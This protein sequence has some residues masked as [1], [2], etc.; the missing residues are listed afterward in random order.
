MALVRLGGESV[1]GLRGR[2]DPTYRRC[3]KVQCSN[4]YHMVDCDLNTPLAIF[5]TPV[6][7]LV[8]DGELAAELAAMTIVRIAEGSSIAAVSIAN[9]G[10]IAPLVRLVVSG[11]PTVQQTSAAALAAIGLVPRCRNTIANAGAIPPLVQQLRSSLLGSPETAARTLAHLARDDGCDID[12]FGL[13]TFAGRGEVDEMGTPVQAGDVTDSNDDEGAEESGDG[14]VLGGAMRRE[15]VLDAGGVDALISMLDGSNIPGF[16]T[17][18]ASGSAWGKA[19]VGVAGTIEVAPIFPGSQVDF[20][21]RIGMQEQAAATIADLAL[22]DE[23]MQD[24]IIDAVGVPPLLNLIRIGTSLAQEHAARALWYLAAM[25]DNQRI[26]VRHGAISDLVIL[27]KHGSVNAQEA[28]AAGL[29]DLARGAIIAREEPL[30]DPVTQTHP[31]KHGASGRKIER[32]TRLNESLPH[33]GMGAAQPSTEAE[34]RMPGADMEREPDR[35]QTIA[36]AGGIVPLV[37]LSESG[38]SGG[39]EHAAAALWHLALDPEN[40]ASIASNGGIKPLVS[41]LENGTDIG[42]R[43]ASDALT[44]LATENQDNQAQIAKRLVGLLDHDDGALPLTTASC[45]SCQ[46]LAESDLFGTS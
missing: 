4:T 1:D 22:G 23:D 21:M 7:M 33:E 20:G 28:A 46:S 10:G 8:T 45:V 12:L 3:A 24:A 39:K 17:N 13:G 2:R 11:R 18:K 25:V 26:L 43:H 31:K 44:R 37:K 16:D 6:Q 27:L 19:R 35:L 40:R 38:T 15:K 32:R 5:G 30:M 14:A 9:A 42:Q 29:S 41:L 34:Q 36:E